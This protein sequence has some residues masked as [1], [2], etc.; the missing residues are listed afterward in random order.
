MS[1]S[2]IYDGKSTESAWISGKKI[3]QLKKNLNH[4]QCVI[5]NFESL[6]IYQFVLISKLSYI[7][8]R[9]FLN[10]LFVLLHA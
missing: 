10:I 3:K 6:F 2:E 7:K 1:Y 8:I 9:Q 5:Y 4:I